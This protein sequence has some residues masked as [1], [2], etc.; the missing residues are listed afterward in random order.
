MRHQSL[1]RALLRWFSRKARDLPWRRTRDPYGIWVSEIM[2]QQT[3]VSTVVP[4][5]ERWVQ[6]LP[7][8]ESL[9][10][11]PASKLHKLW[12]GLGYYSRVRN[13]QRAAV[14][15]QQ[16]HGGQFPKRFEEIMGL[17][18]I[19]RYT[20]G[21]IC[22]I[23]YNEPV[24]A[25]DGNLVRVL[26]RIFAVSGDPR[27]KSTNDCL[28]NLAQE[29]VQTAAASRNTSVPNCSFLNQSLMEL[30]AVICTPRNPQCRNCPVVKFCAAYKQKRVEELPTPAARQPIAQRIYAAFVIEHGNRFLA[31]QRPSGTINAHLWEFPNIEIKN[32]NA[33]T[34]AKQLFGDSTESLGRIMVIKHSITRYRITLQV[35]GARL[36]KPIPQSP[37]TSRWLNRTELDQLAFVAAHRKI[38]QRLILAEAPGAR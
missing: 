15:I 28:W 16:Q 18:G 13:L 5:W 4:Y 14:I 20:A 25:V 10:V 27:Q 26:A 7:T 31:W 33:R 3:Q 35:F 23:A 30:G 24:P 22:S 9:A 2:L 21:A 32:S 29:L 37:P 38:I 12:E 17:P 36:S 6:E 34:A 11:C 8:I 19:G 1:V